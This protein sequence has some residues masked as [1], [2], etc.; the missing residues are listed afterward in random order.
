MVYGQYSDA[1]DGA[2]VL[3]EFEPEHAADT[4]PWP[5][6]AYLI[7]SW[8][9]G[10]TQAVIFSAY[11]SDGHDE[12]WWDLH[13]YFARQSDVERQ[14][15]GVLEITRAAF[16]FWNDRLICSG[17][18]DFC[19]PAGNAKTDKGSSVQV[20]RTYGIFPGFIRM[21]LQESL[22]VYNRLLHKKDRFE[23]PIYRIDK[24]TCPM[25]YTASIGGY[26]YPVEGEPGFGG[27]EPLKGSAGGDFDHVADASR[28]AKYN[29]LRAIRME[30]EQ[31]KKLV[32]ALD[33][34]EIP[35]RKKR[36]Y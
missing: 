5:Q 14:A 15:K 3:Y 10:T 31:S 8:D 35:N 32:G 18:K 20:L 2:P 4:L 6:G 16:P 19:D 36:Y 22:A 11:W 27:D 23:K 28:Y 17:V 9:F 25:L 33:A 1:F 34:K 26:R 21:G 30:V 29:L 7:R 13:E 24:T 12:Y